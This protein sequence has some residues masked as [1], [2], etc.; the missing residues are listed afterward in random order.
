VWVEKRHFLVHDDPVVIS[1]IGF[2]VYFVVKT[3]TSME[4]IVL[5]LR[6]NW[7]QF[8]LLV[9]ING[10]VGGMVGLERSILPQIATHEFGVAAKSAILSFIVAFGLVKALTNYYAG[11]LAGR[12]GRKNLL[13]AGWAFGIPIPFMLIYAP[14][15]D[16]IIAAN[17]LLG[18]NQGL[19]WSSTVVMQWFI[20]PSWPPSQRRPIH[21]TGQEHWGIQVVEGSGVCDWGNLYWS[22]RRYDEYPN[23]YFNG[24]SAHTFLGGGDPLSDDLLIGPRSNHPEL[25][26]RLSLLRK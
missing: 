16:W 9:V 23:R 14:G 21:S 6:E 2:P 5:G 12:Y 3:P 7:R 10:F 8:A 20:R 1:L 19:A 25:F 24:W 13:V 11:A 22:D 15:W 18:V 17:M 26:L 4:R